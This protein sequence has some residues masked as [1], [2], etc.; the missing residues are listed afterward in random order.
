MTYTTLIHPV[1]ID[2]GQ[3]STGTSPNLPAK[4]V[5]CGTGHKLPAETAAHAAIV[6]RQEK[7]W[8]SYATNK[9]SGIMDKNYA[10]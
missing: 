2:S 7:L 10:E 4:R 1:P 6:V 3:F 8:E 5:L 9:A